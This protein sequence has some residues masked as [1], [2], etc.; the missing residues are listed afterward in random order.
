ML[1]ATN[2]GMLVGTNL[3]M[4]VGTNLAIWRQLVATNIMAIYL[5]KA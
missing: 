2:L 3:G 5:S 1:V 4:L